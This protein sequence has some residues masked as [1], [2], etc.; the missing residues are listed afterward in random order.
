MAQDPGYLQSNFT[1]V[2]EILSD[3]H[4]WKEER[5]YYKTEVDFLRQKI[6][7]IYSSPAWKISKPLRILNLIQRKFFPG[8]LEPLESIELQ[9][10]TDG[11]TVYESC[12]GNI[13]F[14]SPLIPLGSKPIAILAQWS[15]TA[16]IPISTVILIKEILKTGFDL[17]LV[18]ACE[19]EKRLA[20][21]A[22]IADKITIIRKPNTGY[23]F[24]SWSVGLNLIPEGQLYNEFLILND[25]LLGPFAS[26]ANIINELRTS[27][28]DITGITDSL[29]TRYHIQSYL[30][31]FKPNVLNHPKVKN[32]WMD[33]REQNQKQS[34][35][36]AYEIGLSRIAQSYGLHVGAIRPWNLIANYWDNPSVHGWKSV[37]ERDIPFIKREVFRRFS[38]LD[39]NEL[40][41]FIS[42]KY[43][44]PKLEIDAIFTSE[45]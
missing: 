30:M 18:S 38:E 24:G 21:P 45:N 43:R 20:I 15:T 27:P 13:K 42:E 39:K 8:T 11:P 22:E 41:K 5:D 12:K 32:F 28:Y 3:L 9:I 40:K 4:N 36:Q 23:D 35:I 33:I 6:H 17:I 26:I 14:E 44:T 29:Q 19:D 31:H 37:L 10:E 16:E 1:S 25:S 7:R 34:V 2:E